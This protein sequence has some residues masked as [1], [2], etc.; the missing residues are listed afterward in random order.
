M[1]LSMYQATVPPLLTALRNLS[2]IL[3]KADANAKARAIEPAVLLGTRLYPDMFPLSRQVQIAAD[4]AKGTAARLAGVEVP[5]F[6][7]VE[8]NFEELRA[9]LAKTADFV[10]SFK[11]EQ[12]DGSD[13]RM[14]T[15][16]VGRGESMTFPG[17]LY[18]QHF[19]LPN[20]YF[21]ATTAYAILRH[22]GVDLGKRDFI[23]APAS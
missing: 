15:V 22:C 2:T 20:L 18:L 7:D 13:A 21:H 8:T 3:E 10:S 6:D 11:P 23:G 16:P 19:A 14:V 4:F 17:L 1:T 5:K 12:F 9:R